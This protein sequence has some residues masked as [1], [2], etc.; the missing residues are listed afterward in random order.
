MN[1]VGIRSGAGSLPQ[2]GRGKGSGQAARGGAAALR[3]QKR[4]PGSSSISILSAAGLLMLADDGR[5]QTPACRPITEIPAIQHPV[6][7]PH[8]GCE[9]APAAFPFGEGGGQVGE[10]GIDGADD[11]VGGGLGCLTDGGGEV[12]RVDR[13]H[14][15]ADPAGAEA[16]VGD[17]G[18]HLAG[19]GAE[20]TCG[21][22]HEAVGQAEG[23]DHVAQEVEIVGHAVGGHAVGEARTLQLRAVEHAGT[24]RFGAEAEAAQQMV[25]EDEADA[26]GS[27]CFAGAAFEFGRA[28]G[29]TGG[30]G[31]SDVADRA[32]EAG[33]RD[34]REGGDQGVEGGVE[35][36]EGEAAGEFSPGEDEG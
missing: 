30:A 4:R 13:V 11:A 36:A 6:Q 25:G 18:D 8:S 14:R 1:D 32:L 2:S 17:E 20:G 23:N 15:G 16:A 10:V 5:S 27:G 33:G 29:L 35:G 21:A 19:E 34:E 28:T 12:V 31:G 26:F 9:Q 22:L 24:E 3:R 7:L